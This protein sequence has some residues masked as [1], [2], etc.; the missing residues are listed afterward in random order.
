MKDSPYF[1]LELFKFFRQLSKH[2]NREWFQQH[3]RRYEEF[4]RDPF[5]KFIED[6]RPRLNAVSPR[7]IADPK[8]SGG[9]LLRIYRDMRFRKGQAPYQTMAAARFPH[10]AWKDG[11]TPG[12][13]LHLDPSHCF[14]A[15]GLWHPDG[16]TRALVRESIMRDSAKWK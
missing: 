15:C 8:P 9:S 6:F 5:L 12:L 4:V 14:F 3:K 10:Q 1:T 13:Y 2:N 11:R 16:D 7:F